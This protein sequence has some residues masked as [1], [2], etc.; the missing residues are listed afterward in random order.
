VSI[1]YTRVA[2][3]TPVAALIDRADEALYY[4]KAHGRNK[5]CGWDA[6]VAAGELKF[7]ETPKSDVTLF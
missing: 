1:G 3:A 7:K 4:A 2:A 6:L 5:V